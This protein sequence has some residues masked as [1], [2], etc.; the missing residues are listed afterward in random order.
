[1]SRSHLRVWRSSV[2][3]VAGVLALGPAERAAAD[4][5]LKNYSDSLTSYKAS[6]K[7]SIQDI[8]PL[9][10]QR[11]VD[12]D[13]T[14]RAPSTQNLSVAG[15]SSGDRW[16]GNQR[17]SG[18][19]LVTGTFLI[20]DVDLGLPAAVPWVIGRSYNGRQKDS[21]GSY[22]ASNGYQGKNW[23][24]SSQPE[25]V[26]YDSA[27]DSQDVIYLVYGADRFIELNRDDAGGSP[28]TTT[29]RAVNGAAGAIVIA[30]DAGGPDLATYY[31]QNGFR[32]VFFWFND[33][34]IDDDI[35]GAIWKVIDPAGNVAYVGHATDAATA[36]SSYDATSGA[37]TTAWDSA[38]RKFTY[39]YTSGRLTQV[40]AEVGTTEV[41]RVDYSY[42]VNA[43]SH[44]ED[45]DLKLVTVTTPLT[46]SG[47]SLAR[48]KFY[49]YYEGT[50]D[51]T[52]N[53]GYLTRSS[54]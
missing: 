15:V 47:V 1:M 6:A 41:G 22:F 18:T 36:L 19:H 21:A 5:I 7:S 53:P 31:D 24:Q 23:F 54:T 28:S 4:Q 30:I 40:K 37:I 51:A 26:F 35:E 45:G 46:D 34:H 44:G 49:W 17:L 43:D 27:T 14:L 12:L 9:V 20:N 25:L 3:L 11:G 38:G 52:N 8:R 10:D 48:K 33:T 42:Y 50:Y 16:N 29:F 39:T 32:M 2:A 13:G